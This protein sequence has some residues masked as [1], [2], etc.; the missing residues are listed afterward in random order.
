MN[1]NGMKSSLKMDNFYFKECSIK[2]TIAIS[3]GELEADLEKKIEKTGEHTYDVEL[4]LTIGK[5]I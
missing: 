4:R 3:D 5:R 1:I 2:R